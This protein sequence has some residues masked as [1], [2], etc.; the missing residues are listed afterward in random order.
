MWSSGNTTKGI[1]ILNTTKK[2]C[3]CKAK[4]IFYNT[5]FYKVNS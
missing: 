2:T 4:D 5:E 3:Y 1:A